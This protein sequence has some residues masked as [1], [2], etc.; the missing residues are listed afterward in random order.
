MRRDHRSARIA[1]L[2]LVAAAALAGCAVEDTTTAL[3]SQ[4]TATHPVT[5]TTA[6]PGIGTSGSAA[7]AP[8]RTTPT[9]TPRTAWDQ[10]A[11]GGKPNDGL[12]RKQVPLPDS[13]WPD[14]G[15]D[16][17]G[18]PRESFIRRDLAAYLLRVRAKDRRTA[19]RLG[20]QLLA[21]PPA[22][23]SL[24]LPN[25]TPAQFDAQIRGADRRGQRMANLLDVDYR[26][27]L[28]ARTATLLTFA[29]A[30]AGRR[31]CPEQ[32][33]HPG[34][35]APVPDGPGRFFVR[36]FVNLH[37][38]ALPVNWG[39]GSAFGRGTFTL[40]RETTALAYV[41]IL[42]GYARM[43]WK[44]WPVHID[45]DHVREFLTDATIRETATN[46]RGLATLPYGPTPAEIV[47]NRRQ[48]ATEQAQEAF[49]LL[50]QARDCPRA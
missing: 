9:P 36:D 33:A 12:R 41:D 4:R 39:Y 47:H 31:F 34:K 28:T 44:Q 22:W 29:R 3:P 15:S 1:A 49:D 27:P 48:A 2:A 18:T 46:V 16:D 25:R 43:V 10:M 19:D 14:R 30:E 6:T 21:V 7:A 8:T 24:V 38:S 32:A 37:H 50:E 23:C 5:T 17:Y 26:K 42:S 13:Y 11:A 20:W 45:C 35:P 40:D